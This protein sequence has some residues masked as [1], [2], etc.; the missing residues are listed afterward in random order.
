MISSALAPNFQKFGS[1][2]PVAMHLHGHN[3]LKQIWVDHLRGEGESLEKIGE[4]GR[5]DEY[6]SH[7]RGQEWMVLPEAD[8]QRPFL[9]GDMMRVHC[10]VH[11]MDIPPV[12]NG[13]INIPY[14]VQ[15]DTEMCAALMMYKNHDD[16]Y[17]IRNSGHE[18]TAWYNHMNGLV[19]NKVFN[20]CA[21]P[22]D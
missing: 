2:Q 10:I 14:G 6:H 15:H 20:L 1:I 12:K 4:Y 21:M 9:P 16:A 3:R 13:G 22:C 17:E 7:G 8:R 18:Y 5:I 11:T 19:V